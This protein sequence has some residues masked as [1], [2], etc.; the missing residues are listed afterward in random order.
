MKTRCREGGKAPWE[1]GGRRLTLEFGVGLSPAP[2]FWKIKRR[3]VDVSLVERER[4]RETSWLRI[5]RELHEFQNGRRNEVIRSR[6]GRVEGCHR[7]VG[8]RCQRMNER[9]TRGS[10]GGQPVDGGK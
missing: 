1:E 8:S 5:A 4:N 2:A 9:D 10:R 6:W 7:L 3:G